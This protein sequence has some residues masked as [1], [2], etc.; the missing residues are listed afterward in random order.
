MYKPYI[1]QW[2]LLK[3]GQLIIMAEVEWNWNG[4]H[5]FEVFDAV[6]CILLQPLQ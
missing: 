4:N 6:P 1:H 5:V 3:G 2:R